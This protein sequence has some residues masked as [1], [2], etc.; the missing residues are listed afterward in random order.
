[1]LNRSVM[2]IFYPIAIIACK[3]MGANPVGIVILVQSACLTAF[4]TPMSCPVAAMITGQGGYTFRS[5]VKQ[6]ILPAIL[7][8]VVVVVWIITMFPLY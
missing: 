6:S 1:M 8:S 7:F 4:V 3:A 5:I 2:M